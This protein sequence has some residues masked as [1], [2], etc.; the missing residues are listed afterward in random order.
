MSQQKQARHNTNLR[1]A[2]ESTVTLADGNKPKVPSQKRK[3]DAK[4]T[5][6][7]NRI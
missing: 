2:V 6:Y 1:I 7:L 4:Q 5:L 3:E